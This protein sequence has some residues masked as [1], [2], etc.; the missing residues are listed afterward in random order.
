MKNHLTAPKDSVAALYFLPGQYLFK[1]IDKKK[2]LEIS[3]ALSSEQITLAFKDFQSDTGWLARPMV[4]Y[5]EKP[6]GNSFLSFEPAGIKQI[7]IETKKGKVERIKL[8][9]PALVLLGKGNNYYLWA[10][11]EKRKI[12]PET[13]LAVAPLPNIGGEYSGKICFGSNEVPE[14]RAENIESVWDF[15][16]NSPFNADQKNNKCVS[17]PK[18]VRQLLLKLSKQKKKSFPVSELFVSDTTIE[19]VWKQIVEGKFV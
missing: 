19:T 4:R 9:L 1:R 12:T 17:E 13:Q 5:L 15:V 8:P 3:K 10:A 6:E 18:D 14:A 7:L 16:F 11:K 2:G